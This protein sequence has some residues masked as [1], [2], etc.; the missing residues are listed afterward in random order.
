MRAE[1][2]LS[3]YWITVNE[4]KY[5]RH[6]NVVDDQGKANFSYFMDCLVV[7]SITMRH[8]LQIDYVFV[9]KTNYSCQINVVK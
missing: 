5:K 3:V 2:P 1:W 7:K 6:I 4:L 9:C 8:I